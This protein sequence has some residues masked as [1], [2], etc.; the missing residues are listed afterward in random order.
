MI[1][2]S[3]FEKWHQEHFPEN[4]L[5]RFCSLSEPYADKETKARF[6][7]WQLLENRIKELEDQLEKVTARYS[8][9]RDM[10]PE[11]FGYLSTIN[12]RFD[13]QVDELI[14]EHSK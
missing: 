11:D 9:V 14:K 2:R 1:N 4:S 6:E 7:M 13:E 12:K 8:C 10:T 3:D 5:M